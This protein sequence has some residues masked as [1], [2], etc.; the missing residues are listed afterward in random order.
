[1]RHDSTS[2]LLAYNN[3][4]NNC[5]VGNHANITCNILITQ[6]MIAIPQYGINQFALIHTTGILKTVECK[7]ESMGILV[8][9]ISTKLDK[10]Q[11]NIT[12]GTNIKSIS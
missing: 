10:K 5:Y 11:I 4:I 8:I 1:M 2:K 12:I 3:T 9:R 7:F 6:E